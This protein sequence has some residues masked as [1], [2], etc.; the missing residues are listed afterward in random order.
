MTFITEIFSYGFLARAVL[1][2]GL[3]SLCAAVLGVSLVLKRYSMIGDGLGHVGFGALCFAFALNWAPIAVSMPLVALAAFVLL[4]VSESAKIKGDAAIGLISSSALAAGILVASESGGLNIDVTGYMFGS[5]LS[6]SAT[7]AIVG[8]AGCAAVLA[9]YAVFQGKIFAV[10]F[11]ETFARAVGMK[12]E[13]YNILLALL[14]AVTVVIGMRIM[15]TLLISSLIVFPALSAM[16]LGKSF[17]SVV[18][19][20]AAVSLICFMV[21]IKAAYIFS[22]P[23]GAS[24]V[25]V[26]AAA[27]GL[28]FILAKCRIW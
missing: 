16:R 6:M 4:R 26:N 17:R 9:V 5:V 21:G 20:S 10:T 2:G 8:A 15:G 3:V 18:I 14:T 22:A 19:I 11:D 28:I 13:R 23:A 12:A 25:A 7:D 1:V 24:V 27:F